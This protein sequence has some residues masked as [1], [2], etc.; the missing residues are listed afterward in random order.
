MRGPFTDFQTIIMLLLL[1][2][3]I[4]ASLQFKNQY[5]LYFKTRNSTQRKLC[6]AG[7]SFTFIMVVCYIANIVIYVSGLSQGMSRG[8]LLPGQW[9]IIFSISTVICYAVS[10]I[11]LAFIV[12]ASLQRYHRLCSVEEGSVYFKVA[13]NGIYVVSVLGYICNI[14]SVYISSSIVF[15]FGL[16]VCLCFLLGMDF[17]AN[18][19]VSP[20]QT[21]TVYS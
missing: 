10:Y 7:A 9:P 11:A 1:A 18:Y 19:S 3:L 4:A 2:T 14:T 13:I 17:F 20:K 8:R 21:I 5:E 12:N 16:A 6:L 15:D